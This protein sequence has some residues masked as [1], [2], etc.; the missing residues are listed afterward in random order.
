MLKTRILPTLLYKNFG[1]VK[2]V[3]FDSSR[4]A[5]SLMQAVKVF[6]MREVDE[7]MFLDITATMENR[8]PDLELVDDFA[9][10]CFMPLTVGGGIRSVEDVRRLLMVGA[11]KVCVN[12]AAVETPELIGKIANRFGSQ[13]LVISIDVARTPDGHEICTHSGTRRVSMDP[14][15][16]A[17]RAEGEGAGEI[18]LTSV[19]RDGTMDGYDVEIIKRVTDAVDIA[20]IASGGAGEYEHMYEAIKGGGASAIAAASIF[21]FTERTPREAKKYLHSRGVPVRL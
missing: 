3:R 1:L 13:S 12:T 8:G 6:N 16:L 17:R 7:L 9:D 11:D 4:P 10:E 20:V 19:D 2:G 5:G 14:V 15:E 21:L 18:L